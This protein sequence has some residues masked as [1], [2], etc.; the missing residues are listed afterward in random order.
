[1][2][3]PE[4]CHVEVLPFTNSSAARLKI[5]VRED[6]QRVKTDEFHRCS[7][8]P[9]RMLTHYLKEAFRS[10]NSSAAVSEEDKCFVLG[11]EILAFEG[12]EKSRTGKLSAVLS[13]SRDGRTEYIPVQLEV[14]FSE[15]DGSSSENT[16]VALRKASAELAAETAEKIRNWGSSSSMKNGSRRNL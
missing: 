16:V 5:L 14:P 10:K 6:S 1:M 7:Q 12:N 11:G 4:G 9:S 8:T 15:E 13:L 2:D 3:L